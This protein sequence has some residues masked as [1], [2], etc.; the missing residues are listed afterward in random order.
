MMTEPRVEKKWSSARLWPRGVSL[1]IVLL[2]FL[3][4]ILVRHAGLLQFLEFQGYDF[5][6]RH[7]RK[8][9]TSDPIVLVEMT[10]ADI[11]NPTLDYPIYDNKLADLLRM[12]EA[13]QPAVIGLDLWR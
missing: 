6:V 3:G 2:V 10:E 5:F 4:T 8:A 1:A 12:L 9:A 11:H 13:G 7:E